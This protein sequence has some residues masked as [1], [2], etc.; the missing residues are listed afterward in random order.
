VTSSAGVSTWSAA[1][2]FTY[3]SA[4]VQP[5]PDSE[6]PAAGV[7]AGGENGVL[8]FGAVAGSTSSRCEVRLV[9]PRLAVGPHGRV[10]VPL[11]RIGAAACGGRLTL[12][13]RVA[14]GRRR[15]RLMVLGEGAFAF[16]AGASTTGR[17]AL[18]AA[19]R[20]LLAAGH[21]R[22]RANL[23]VITV[24]GA[25]LVP[26]GVTAAGLRANVHRGR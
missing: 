20:M 12:T 24:A 5:P 11:R 6:S 7:S 1:D 14:R 19:G 21:G 10:T 3:V 13:A 9:S 16:G 25:R 22:L 8:A 2:R 23:G 17:V 4:S 26:V 15:P 18:D